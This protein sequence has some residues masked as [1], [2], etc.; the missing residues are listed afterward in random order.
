MT[1]QRRS[2]TVSGTVQGVG[3]RPFVFQIAQALGLS[4]WVRNDG[5]SVEIEV[6]GN[7]EALASFLTALQTDAPPLAAIHSVESRSISAENVGGFRI[8]ASELSG[9]GLAA[10]PPDIAPC[11][12]CLDELADPQNR[13][14]GYPFTCCTNCGPRYTVV[15]GLP[16]DRGATSMSSFGL[17]DECLIEY[18]DPN[19][20]RFHAQAT[21][22]STCGPKLDGGV[23]QLVELLR[24]GAIVAV[25]GLGGYQLVCRADRSDT[26]AELRSRKRREQK[27]FAVL[28]GSLATATRLVQLDRVGERA[29]AGQEAPIVLAPVRSAGETVAE[30]VA[31]GT[32][33]LGVMLPS[34]PLHRLLVDGVGVP[35]VCTSGNLSEEPIIV[36]DAIA[37]KRLWSIADGFLSHD[38]A[39]ERRADDSVGQVVSGRFQL[40]R[41]ARGFAPRPISMGGDGPPVL[42]VGAELKSTVCL[43][44]GTEAAVSVHLGDLENPA[45]LA[46]FEHA[47]A[48]QLALTG[49]E[50]ELIVHDLHP[51]YLSTKF[52]QSQDIAPTL[53]VQHHHA[54]LVSCLVDNGHRGPAIGITFDGLG[55]G[56]DETAW[57]G[58][59]LVGDATG[60]VRAA[61][62]RHVVLPGGVAALR[63]PWRMALANMVAAGADTVTELPTLQCFAKDELALNTVF[64]LCRDD[65]SAVTSSMGRLF[66]AVA[67][68]CGVGGG[69]DAAS[70]AMSYEGQAAIG[71]EQ[72]A[73][74]GGRGG[75]GDLRYP[76]LIEDG[77]PLI[78]DAAPVIAAIVDDL[79]RNRPPAE[80]AARFHRSVADLIVDLCGRQQ[81][82]DG[83]DVVA[84][85]GGVF[86]NRLLV[87]LVVPKLEA[88]GFTVLRH[89]QVPPNDG[90][91][92]LGQVAIGRAYLA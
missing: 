33:L 34:T 7:S 56:T 30:E 52:A 31:P 84:L 63:E 42:G 32:G 79:S 9:P 71:L 29:L 6:E 86:Q 51:E 60:Y 62:L 5:R 24:G 10:I 44:S 19:D 16:Y 22:C 18:R 74:E 65:R 83:L 87:E 49:I 77:G 72:L 23:D 14:F 82:V 91:I 15:S 69:P 89:A 39:I 57:G 58:E 81:A 48:D 13:R 41:R 25:K 64:G 11:S 38:R 1:G 35:L 8:L 54:H 28:V 76:W 46:A 2:I 12:D 26:V 55:F 90:G 43:A 70:G 59:V 36:D 92:S 61:H 47:I 4:G 3:F 17:C 67:A 88:E 66:D 68:L 73:S 85:T 20:R 75:A 37:R 21:C 78:I 80:V 27:P 40:L 45:T 50:P 53:A